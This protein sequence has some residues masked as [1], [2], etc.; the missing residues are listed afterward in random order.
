MLW[1]ISSAP[2]TNTA[3]W[4]SSFALFFLLTNFS[5]THSQDFFCTRFVWLQ[6]LFTDNWITDWWCLHQAHLGGLFSFFS[7]NPLHIV[8]DTV[9][10]N[11]LLGFGIGSALAWRAPVSQLCST[12]VRLLYSRAS[13]G[14]LSGCR[15]SPFLWRELVAFVVND[16]GSN[17]RYWTPHCA[18]IR[19]LIQSRNY[20]L[21]FIRTV[22]FLRNW[23]RKNRTIARNQHNSLCCCSTFEVSEVSSRK[24][25]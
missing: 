11:S 3:L 5:Q 13:C 8:T 12:A 17:G 6:Q 1:F 16:N 2:I 23:T 19:N 18:A 14:R 22:L 24:P 7:D 9:Y 25:G 20:A 21:F 10:E 15:C 4:M